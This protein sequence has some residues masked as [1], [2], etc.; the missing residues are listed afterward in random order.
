MGIRRR[1]V[2]VHGRRR[3]WQADNRFRFELSW[4][5]CQSVAKSGREGYVT[6]WETKAYVSA[7]KVA[8]KGG[9]ES[10]NSVATNRRVVARI[11]GGR[12]PEIATD[13]GEKWRC[14]GPKVVQKKK[15]G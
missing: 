12:S 6:A 8:G 10:E 7:R 9:M 5:W 3:L 1:P 14:F 2:Q 13:V 11:A 15:G 4:A